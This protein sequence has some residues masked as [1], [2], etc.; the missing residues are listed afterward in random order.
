MAYLNKGALGVLL[1]VVFLAG[2]S[3]RI[4]DFTTVSTKNVDMDAEYQ[5]VGDT[6]GTDGA[7]FFLRPDLKLA[8]DAALSSAGSNAKYLTNAR[9]HAVSYPFYNKIEVKGDA[10]APANTANAD[11]PVYELEKAGEGTFLVSEDG[12]ERIKVF[13]S[14]EHTLES[15]PRVK[16]AR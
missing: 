15:E 9:V 16:Q 2:C 6:E 14:S 11:G 5:K 12:S 10:W 8:V 13:K 3:T 7:F 1:A 4:A